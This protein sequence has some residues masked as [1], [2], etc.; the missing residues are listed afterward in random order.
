MGGGGGGGSGEGE[1]GNEEL[2]IGGRGEREEWKHRGMGKL[3]KLR[4][5]V[6]RECLNGEWEERLLGD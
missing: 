1:R 3:R 6:M 5:E 4:K 2:G